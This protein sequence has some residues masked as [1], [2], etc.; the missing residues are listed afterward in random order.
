MKKIKIL[1]IL[2]LS[3]CCL[4]TSCGG[5]FAEESLD[6]ASIN[7]TVLEDGSTQIVISY[8][9]E[10]IAPTTF[11]IPKGVQGESGNGIKNVTYDKSPDGKNTIVTLEFTDP[12]MDAVTIS[13]PNGVSIDKIDGKKDPIT[14]E[15]NITIYY[16]DGTKSNPIS[17]PKGEKGEDGISIIGISQ[18]I[19]SDN[20]VTLTLEMSKGD[21]VIVEIP[22]PQQGQDGR[23]IKDI[24]TIPDGDK[25][26]M[27]ITYT[28]DTST[29]LEFAR[30]N[31]WFSESSQPTVI[32]GIN[33]DL[34]FD[35]A[36]QV[37][38]VKQNNKW[39]EVIDF[40][41]VVDDT[42]EVT[43]NLNDS[44]TAKASMPS[45]SLINYQ[46]PC[47][48][49]FKASGFNIPVPTRNGYEFVGWCTAKIPTTVNGYFNDLTVVQADLTLYAIWEEVK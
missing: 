42:Y 24:V 17:I 38:Y 23:G 4:L 19:N 49:Y 11:I 30:P 44:T 33:G 27:T 40:G 1:M 3:L 31:K 5:F 43:F 7:S 39:T 35:L 10:E 26:I 45:G 32:D 37:I 36:H 16:S 47:G 18:R 46:I 48:S 25:Y 22:A 34:W 15:T 29:D 8:T 20:S 28:D 9:D 12:T 6:I 13:L 41:K 21:N 2:I 14:E